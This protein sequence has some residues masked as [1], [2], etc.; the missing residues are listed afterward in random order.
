MQEACDAA[1][2]P[3]SQLSAA[4]A[5]ALCPQ[6]RLPPSA[7]CLLQP[8]GGAIRA[9]DAAAAVRQLAAGKG[10]MLRVRAAAALS[11]LHCMLTCLV[12]S[13]CVHASGLLCCL[14]RPA[15]PSALRALLQ[16]G[17]QL[18]GWRDRGS[19]FQLRASSRLAPDLVSLYEAEALLLAPPHWHNACLGLFG[20]QLEGLT[21]RVL[22]QTAAA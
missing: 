22:G 21:V 1:G 3:A 9:G 10:V 17:L 8:D 15:H 5:T 18:R 6:L 2:V 12:N 11:V 13:T 14:K 19:C 7:A 20:L 4:E 16:D